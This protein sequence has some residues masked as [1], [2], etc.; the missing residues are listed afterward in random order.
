VELVRPLQRATQYRRP[1]RE[2]DN[3]GTFLL[4]IM[5]PER[6]TLDRGARRESKKKKP[7]W[8]QRKHQ[9]SESVSSESP[10]CKHSVSYAE[11][12]RPKKNSSI[13]ALAIELLAD[14]Q[15]P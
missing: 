15:V 5:L 7:V 3:G 4:C 12:C 10:G 1:N 9:K 13:R 14:V 11:T 6:T 2:K 8:E